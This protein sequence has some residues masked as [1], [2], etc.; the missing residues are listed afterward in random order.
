[1][2]VRNFGFRVEGYYLPIMQ[3]DMEKKMETV[4]GWRQFA[5]QQS[6]ALGWYKVLFHKMSGNQSG[7][8]YHTMSYH[9]IPFYT[10]LSPTIHC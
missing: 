7:D 9:I 10:L 1:M 6:A 4:L 5:P 8:K 2:I 3:N